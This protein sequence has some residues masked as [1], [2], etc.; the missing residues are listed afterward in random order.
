M[1]TTPDPITPDQDPQDQ[2]QPGP[3]YIQGL[4]VPP[5][6]TDPDGRTIPG[7]Y[8]KRS[9]LSF[10]DKIL[11]VSSGR[12]SS[13]LHA[14]VAPIRSDAEIARIGVALKYAQALLN[15]ATLAQV[16]AEERRSHHNTIMYNLR[17]LSKDGDAE[18]ARVAYGILVDELRGTPDAPGTP[19]FGVLTGRGKKQRTYACYTTDMA[20]DPDVKH[21]YAHAFT[22]GTRGPDLKSY[23]CTPYTPESARDQQIDALL[24]HAGPLLQPR[25]GVEIWTDKPTRIYRIFV[26][27]MNSFQDDYDAFR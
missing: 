25:D 8:T 19:V 3:A 27:P 20:Y 1:T 23:T 21:T 18:S 6:R 4:N 10:Q 9:K 15:A 13:V 24:A 11:A 2:T 14:A 26:L 16:E 22:A 5:D 17:A 7:L 12:I